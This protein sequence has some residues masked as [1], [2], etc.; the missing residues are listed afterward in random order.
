MLE[1][2]AIDGAEAPRIAAS[3]VSIWQQIEQALTP[4]LGA[5]GVAALFKRALFLTKDRYPWLEEAF[6][7]IEASG[8]RSAADLFGLVLGRQSAASAAA[9]GAAFLSTFHAVLVSMIGPTL[10]ERL[11]LSVW[12]TFSSGPPAQDISP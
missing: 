8:G 1:T 4:I 9:G 12:T 2:Q 5:R 3:V 7:A 11:L 10:T 6:A